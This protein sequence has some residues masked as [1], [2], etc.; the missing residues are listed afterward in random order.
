MGRKATVTVEAV[1]RFVE[2]LAGEGLE[3]T[4]ERVR[5]KLG[6]G[7]YTSISRILN[8]VLA[9]RRAEATQVTQLPPD[10]LEIGQ[11]AV[12]AIYA[13]VK[14]SA[15]A[16]IELIESDARKHID[17]ANHARAEAALEIERLERE[18]EQGAEALLLAQK[19]TQEAVTRAERAEATAVAQGTEITRLNQ[20]L[21]A[22]QADVQ[23]THESERE[24]LQRAHRIEEAR[25]TSEV[26]SRAEIER[27]QKESTRAQAHREACAEEIERFK[28][29]L[30]AAEGEGKEVRRELQQLQG[31]FSKLEAVAEGAQAGLKG[32]RLELVE[33][34]VAE[35]AARDQTAELRGQIKAAK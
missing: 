26:A 14:Q 8:E 29:L 10:L 32:V 27:L 31:R 22:M 25:R 6:G 28:A 9:Q 7:S 18:G 34:R 23:A 19:A 1:T 30:A 35:R 33:A 24:A 2:A 15:A 3:P 5:A 11:R 20:T 17:A 21:V 12:G 13:A 16:K 4:M